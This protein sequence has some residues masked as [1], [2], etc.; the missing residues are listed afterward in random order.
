MRRAVVMGVGLVAAFGAGVAAGHMERTARADL[1]PPGTVYVPTEGLV[2]RS[3][4]G[5]AIARLGYDAHGGFFDLYEGP[6]HEAHRV[7]ANS[8]YD[9]G[10]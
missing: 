6:A 3:T 2:F 5:R 7:D 1:V 9:F 10:F 4:D 8:E